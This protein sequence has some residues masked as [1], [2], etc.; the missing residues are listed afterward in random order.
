VAR[1]TKKNQ[2][3]EELRA[4]RKKRVQL[5][6]V[7]LAMVAT[8]ALLVFAYI[9][10]ADKNYLPIRFVKVEGKFKYLQAEKLKQLLGQELNKGFFNVDIDGMQMSVKQ[11]PW[12][13]H[14]SV[15]RKWPDTL[16]LKIVEQK[17]L[18]KWS[19]GGY[20]NHRG[21]W[22]YAGD[23]ENGQWPVLDGP[24]GSEYLLSKEYLLVSNQ[25]AKL[26]LAVRRL[27]VNHRRSWNL[28]LE[29]GLDLRLGRKQ[30]QTRLQRFL[31]IY[32]QVVA[33]QLEKIERVDMRYTNGFAVQWKTES[34][35]LKN[36]K[37]AASNA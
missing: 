3:Q 13:D 12:V 27:T 25:L 5:F 31:N 8:G 24:K 2:M 22:F 33:G 28:R 9:T 23:F 35:L 30:V 21:E 19:K 18:A 4:R 37:G 14:V 16:V 17:P 11:V 15:R 36:N 29:N 10:I 1:R 6:S 34:E 7:M 20:V 26:D 32:P